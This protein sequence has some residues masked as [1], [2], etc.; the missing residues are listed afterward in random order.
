MKGGWDLHLGHPEPQSGASAN[1]SARPKSEGPLGGWKPQ[2]PP[3]LIEVN[4]AKSLSALEAE[5][6]PVSTPAASTSFS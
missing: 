4:I 2:E 3:N 6:V 1:E 5:S